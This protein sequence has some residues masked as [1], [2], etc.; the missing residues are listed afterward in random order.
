MSW[1]AGVFSKD[2]RETR[3]DMASQ[4]GIKVFFSGR[5][6]DELWGEYTWYPEVLGRDGRQELCRRMWEDL[7]RADIET[8]DRETKIAAAHGAEMLLP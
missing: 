1:L 6:P 5:G 8:L 2:A 3:Q 4:D 7:T